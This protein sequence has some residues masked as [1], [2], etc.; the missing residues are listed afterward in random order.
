MPKDDYE[1][2]TILVDMDDTIENLLVH[3]IG[4]LNETHGTSVDA[5][6]I[7]SWN[8]Q[9]AFPSLTTEQVYEPLLR[10]EFWLR[11]TP[12]PDAQDYLQT[13]AD[14]GHEIYITTSS[15]YKTIPVKMEQ[16][17]F[18]YFP[19][20]DWDH[21]IIAS[22]KQMIRGDVMVDDGPH[23]LEG[24][25]YY[26]ILMDAPHNRDYRGPNNGWSPV[27]PASDGARFNTL[28]DGTSYGKMIRAANWS[29]VYSVITHLAQSL[30]EI[31][32][33]F[34]KSADL[35]VKALEEKS[36]IKE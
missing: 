27:I 16:V 26:K 35:F 25:R 19:W 34:K 7:R 21:V 17:L 2:L 11:V 8:I 14:D 1:K 31:D 23:N 15:N 6:E 24:G 22:R 10:D 3:W 20:L 33:E 18:K 36:Y 28:C 12:K 4:W 29:E 32:E 9:E 13:L 5:E 30:Y